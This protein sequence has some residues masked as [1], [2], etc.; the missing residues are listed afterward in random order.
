MYNTNL[1]TEVICYSFQNKV[2]GLGSSDNLMSSCPY[3]LMSLERLGRIMNMNETLA[4][5]KGEAGMATD[6]CNS[7]LL[8]QHGVCVKYTNLKEAV[9]ECGA[10]TLCLGLKIVHRHRGLGTVL[11]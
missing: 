11:L 10:V 5:F 8:W 9:S 7:S 3:H 1:N 2:L 4:A 6:N